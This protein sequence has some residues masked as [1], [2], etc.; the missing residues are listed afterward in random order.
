M[1]EVNPGCT[2]KKSGYDANVWLKFSNLCLKHLFGVKCS[3]CYK[4]RPN[5]LVRKI[6]ACANSSQNFSFSNESGVCILPV[7]NAVLHPHIKLMG[8]LA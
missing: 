1:P 3:S 6:C 7:A 8:L 4:L 2:N 5:F